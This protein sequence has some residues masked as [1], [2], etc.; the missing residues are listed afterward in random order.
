M[1]YTV[2]ETPLGSLMLAGVGETLS[3]VNFYDDYSAA[4]PEA[5]A[6]WAFSTRCLRRAQ[7]QFQQYFDHKRSHFDLDL[8]IRG[9]Q[10]QRSVLKAVAAIP[11][12]QT[13]SYGEI[14]ALL[15]RPK[16]ARAVGRANGNNRLPI[17]IPCHRVIAS[18]GRLTGYN[19]GGI[20]IKQKLIDHERAA[21]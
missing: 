9:T 7:S 1:D 11:Y 13:M 5:L 20:S 21:S 18:D 19:N 10:F 15:G 12:G 16:A 2:I 3:L 4:H 14:A 17:V 6:G 8:D